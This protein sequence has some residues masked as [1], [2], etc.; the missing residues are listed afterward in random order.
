MPDVELRKLLEGREFIAVATCDKALRPNSAPKFILKVDGH[1]VYLV[2]YTIG[3]TW[4]NITA[5][6]RVSLSF[7]DHAILMGYQLNGTVTII[8]KGRV[9]EKMCKEMID[10]EIRLTAQHII[11]EV[12]GKARHEQFEVGITERFIILKVSVREIVQIGHRGDITR[13]KTGEVTY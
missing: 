4:K 6:P 1:T 5:N 12:R 11:E 7:M 9:Y 2:D 3:M 8:Q 13:M 10:K